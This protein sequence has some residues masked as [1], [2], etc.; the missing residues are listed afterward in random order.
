MNEKPL[1]TVGRDFGILDRKNFDSRTAAHLLEV[2]D[3]VIQGLY[4]WGRHR[5]SVV[6]FVLSA[7]FDFDHFVSDFAW[8]WHFF[9]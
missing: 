9:G 8:R 4:V 6:Q 2:S 7:D 3:D 5:H 1:I